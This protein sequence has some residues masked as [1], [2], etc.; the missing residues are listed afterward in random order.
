MPKT[1]QLNKPELAAEVEQRF[2]QGGSPRVMERLSA[3]RMAMSGEFTL[4]QIGLA[5]GRD[6][7]R[8]GA[9]MKVVREDGLPALPALLGLHQGRGRAPQ[10]AGKALSGLRHG[11]QR[12]RWTRAKD[13]AAWLEQRHGISLTPGGARYWLKKAGES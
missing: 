9:W 4:A 7:S 1:F 5:V 3:V 13:A 10:V 6:R 11:L 8:I 2:L 12:G